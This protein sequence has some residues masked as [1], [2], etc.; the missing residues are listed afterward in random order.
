MTLLPAVSLSLLALAAPPAVPG[1][2]AEATVKN[3]LLAPWT[4]PYAGV[5]PFDQVKVG[6]F[7]PALE[8]AMAETL[9]NVEKIATDPAPP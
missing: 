1:A 5:P 6:Q 3:P 4:G 8:A 2:G 7:Q 9:A